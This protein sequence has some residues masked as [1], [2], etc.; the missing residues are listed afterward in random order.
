MKEFI[1]SRILFFGPGD[2]KDK[3]TLNLND[4]DYI[5]ITN[6]MINLF[7]QNKSYKSK[8]ILLTNKL[9]T[10]NYSEDIKKHN[11]KIYCYL[12]SSNIALQHLKNITKKEIYLLNKE[13]IVKG[14]PLGLTS[15]LIYLKNINFKHLYITGVTFYSNKQDIESNY[16]TNYMVKEG[17]EY[18]VLNMDKE[19]HNID[20]NIKYLCNFLKNNHNTYIS[21]ELKQILMYKEL[22]DLPQHHVNDSLFLN[23]SE[24]ILNSTEIKKLLENPLNDGY[25]K[26]DL[27]TDFIKYNDIYELLKKY[28]PEKTTIP[29]DLKQTFAVVGNGDC[30]TNQKMGRNIDSHNSVIRIN[31]FSIHP[32][33]EEDV[34]KK[35]T[36]IVLNE[37]CIMDYLKQGYDG[38]AK[39]IVFVNP[40]EENYGFLLVLYCYLHYTN[41]KNKDKLLLLSKSYRRKICDALNYKHPSSGYISVSIAKDTASKFV[42]IYGFNVNTN[43]PLYYHKP[44]RI[45]YVFHK[46]NHEYLLYKKWASENFIINT[47]N[48]TIGNF[49]VVPKSKPIVRNK[50]KPILK[51]VETEILV[52]SKKIHTKIPT[53][54]DKLDELDTSENEKMIT[55]ESPVIKDIH[56][57]AIYIYGTPYNIEQN[58]KF[59]KHYLNNNNIDIFIHFNIKHL[60]EDINIIKKELNPKSYLFE[61]HDKSFSEIMNDWSLKLKTPEIS[62]IYSLYKCNELRNNYEKEHGKTHD[63]ILVMNFNMTYNE[64][65]NNTLSKIIPKIDKYYNNLY[66]PSNYNGYG[67]NTNFAMGHTKIINIYANMYKWMETVKNKYPLNIE[68]LMC[69]YII[70]NGVRIN[71]INVDYFYLKD[72]K[73]FQSV[74]NIGSMKKSL[75]QNWED[76]EDLNNMEYNSSYTNDYYKIKLE[77]ISNIL[78][79]KINEKPKYYL[80]NT[81]FKKF[82]HINSDNKIVYGCSCNG[83]LFTL[84][85]ANNKCRIVL[86]SDEYYLTFTD[87]IELNNEP[88]ETSELYLIKDN[89]NYSF[90]TIYR[91]N[92]RNK[93]YGNYIGFNEIGLTEIDHDMENSSKFTLMNEHMYKIHI[94]QFKI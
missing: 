76:M 69:K 54:L 46:I 87:K 31:D 1:N 2:T 65:I 80:Y 78:K 53:K 48:S 41:D 18:N 67:I 8:I 10:L 92:N 23:L 36:M 94:K 3:L 68:Y 13:D 75:K 44:S 34:G 33:F 26:I 4:Y 42:S 25:M 43:S 24:L 9:F 74:T 83:T 58:V 57:Y 85:I 49:I 17:Y 84:N 15:V 79:L 64:I 62:E 12:T 60:N 21:D 14:V 71:V 59:L 47:G 70:L 32:K 35:T 45:N 93:K 66:I 20:S 29:S 56:K 89:T 63:Y 61:I 55:I 5:I 11:D 77:S 51:P 90:Q 82:L 73:F 6:N 37:Y 38:D 39:Y 52:N 81:M 19:L 50:I 86:S 72:K 27:L 28:V 40:R 91:T 16:V 7:F 88:T 30:I 22:T